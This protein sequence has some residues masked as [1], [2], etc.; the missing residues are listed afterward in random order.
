LKQRYR[1][2]QNK[3]VDLYYGF[4]ERSVLPPLAE[5]GTEPAGGY[6][7]G[8]AGR[9]GS[10][11][12]IMPS[13]A[14]TDSAE[15][16]RSVLAEGGH[17]ERWVDFLDNQVFPTATNYVALLFATAE[18]RD[19][20]KFLAQVVDKAAFDRIPRDPEWMDRLRPVQALYQPGGWKV[21]P[22]PKFQEPTRSLGD[23]FTVEVGIQ[24]S[25]DKIYLLQFV[26]PAADPDCVVVK[27]GDKEEVVLERAALFACAKG[28]RD[29]QGEELKNKRFVLWTFRKDGSLLSAEE[30]E[31]NFPRAWAYLCRNQQTLKAREK[32]K[33]D[34]GV[35]WRFRRP[36][37][38]R[39]AALPKIIVPSMMEEPTAYHDPV[40]AVICTASGKGGGGGWVLT[41]KPGVD[42][43]LARVAEYLRSQKHKSWLEAN[44]EP[45]QG[46]WWG[47]D[48][49]LLERCPLPVSVVAKPA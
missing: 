35:W 8:L 11:A 24:T 23:F 47:V 17:V 36:Q 48:G 32:G 13:F 37:G 33:F 34:D 19:R 20:K 4:I 15:N 7:R 22:E 12:F 30:I 9:A 41:A 10:I 18:K 21:R 1:T 5:D 16:L 40:G 44:A 46:G 14:Q 39:C 27:N 2:M 43:D 26:G 49:D 31:R 45:K 6:L 29:L 25:K 28:S 38:V 3:N 42:V